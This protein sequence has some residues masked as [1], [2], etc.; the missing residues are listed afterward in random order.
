M[1][2]SNFKIIKSESR[3]DLLK[4]GFKTFVSGV[5][6]GLSAE[7]KWTLEIVCLNEDPNITDKKNSSNLTQQAKN[8]IKTHLWE[9]QSSINLNKQNWIES[10][11]NI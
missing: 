2:R 3:L 11:K 7:T 8:Y 6:V 9:M 10:M 4:K 1:N 5:R